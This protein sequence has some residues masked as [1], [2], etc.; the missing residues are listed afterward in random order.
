VVGPGSIGN[1]TLLESWPVVAGSDF[2]ETLL[3]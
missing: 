3:T 2:M 1:A